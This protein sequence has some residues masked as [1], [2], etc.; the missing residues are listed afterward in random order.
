MFDNHFDIEIDLHRAE[1]SNGRLVDRSVGQGRF[2]AVHLQWQPMDFL[3]RSSQYRKK[4]IISLNLT[5]T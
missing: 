2:G 5:L 3:R 1:N 4:S